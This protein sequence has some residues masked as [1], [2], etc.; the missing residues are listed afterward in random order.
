MKRPHKR[1]ASW[2]LQSCCQSQSFVAWG[3]RG[4]QRLVIA[5]AMWIKRTACANIWGALKIYMTYHF[6]H[7]VVF[8]HLCYGGGAVLQK[9]LAKCCAVLCRFVK[10]QV[11]IPT[12][13]DWYFAL[14]VSVNDDGPTL[15]QEIAGQQTDVAGN[16]STGERYHK[17]LLRPMKRINSQWPNFVRFLHLVCVECM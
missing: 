5:P 14:Y 6:P 10:Q 17:W 3:G 15:T 13:K 1:P 11:W 2:P 9:T 12:L 16:W 4:R 7:F 8:G